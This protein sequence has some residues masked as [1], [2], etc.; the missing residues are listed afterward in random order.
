MKKY[1]TP[2]VFPDRIDPL[3][4]FQDIDIPHREVYNTLKQLLS[5]GRYSDA[6]EYIN[7]QEDVDGYYADLYKLLQQRI[8]NLQYGL[9][10]ADTQIIYDTVVPSKDYPYIHNGVVWFNYDITTGKSSPSS[11]DSLV[12]ELIKD[13]MEMRCITSVTENANGEK[14]YNAVVPSNH[15]CFEDIYLDEEISMK[16][17]FEEFVESDPIWSTSR[18]YGCDEDIV[19][20]YIADNKP[21]RDIVTLDGLKIV[22]KSGETLQTKV[23]DDANFEP[24][25]YYLGYKDEYS[26]YPLHTIDD[27]SIRIFPYENLPNLFF[28]Y[29]ENGKL[30]AR[31]LY[32]KKK[33]SIKSDPSPIPKNNKNYK[34][35]KFRIMTNL[36]TL[37]WHRLSFVTEAEDA[38]TDKG[39]VIEDYFSGYLDYIAT[40]VPKML[41]AAPVLGIEADSVTD[42]VNGYRTKIADMIDTI[43]T[44][45][46]ETDYLEGVT[47]PKGIALYII[48]AMYQPIIDAVGRLAE[49]HGKTMSDN[50]MRSALRVLK[51]FLPSDVQMYVRDELGNSYMLTTKSGERLLFKGVNRE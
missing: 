12:N 34:H 11:Q 48:N 45:T 14:Q 9:K 36:P 30:L 18:V 23:Y 44:L 37:L 47:T 29:D 33:P 15:V 43:G 38:L 13:N 6:M 21:K 3:I 1:E 41:T 46:G 2:S 32:S 24:P 22:T 50:T 19:K 40:N 8:Y 28:V 27:K 4:F 31:Y 42:M 7:S 5:E 16:E 39:V 20:I 10:M 49:R 25:K 51:S 35:I 26:T 17:A